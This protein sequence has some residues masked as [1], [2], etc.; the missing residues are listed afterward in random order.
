MF[1]SF[2]IVC[3]GVVLMM[4][5][6]YLRTSNPIVATTPSPVAPVISQKVWDIPESTGGL[7]L[8]ESARK[9]IGVVTEYD[10]SNGYYAGGEPPPHTGVCTDVISR[11][12]S[13]VNVDFR[14][15]VHTDIVKNST[16]YKNP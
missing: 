7:A 2:L 15:L 5:G 14:S 13:G 11:A 10:H 9:Q 4:V 16:L 3:V 6:N 8:Y 12:F 1:K